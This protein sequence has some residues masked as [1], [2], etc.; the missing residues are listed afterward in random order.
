MHGDTSLPPNNHY[1]FY[2]TNL[3]WLACMCGRAMYNIKSRKVPAVHKAIAPT[4]TPTEASNTETASTV[5]LPQMVLQV[6]CKE[7]GGGKGEY[8]YDRYVEARKTAYLTKRDEA[9]RDKSNA[10]WSEKWREDERRK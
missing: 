6:L 4:A 10:W 7:W 5:N 1:L 2:S 9:D 3:A 8:Y